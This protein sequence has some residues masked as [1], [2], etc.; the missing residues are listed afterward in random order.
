MNDILKAHSSAWLNA[1][2]YRLAWL[3][4]PI[5]LATLIFGLQF[6]ITPGNNLRVIQVPLSYSESENK[7]IS[8]GLQRKDSAT[9]QALRSAAEDDDLRALNYMGLLHE[10]NGPYPGTVA[11][12]SDVALAYYDKAAALGSVH[13]LMN[14]G[15]LLARVSYS[16]KACSYFER[17]FKADPTRD[18][19]R[20]EAGY[21][22]AT[23]PNVSASEKA[24]GIEMMESA[25][26]SGFVR[27]FGLLGNTY[28]HQ[29]P[30][31]FNQ[32]KGNFEKAI[33]GNIDDSGFSYGELGHLYFFGNGI[34]QD[35]KKAVALYLEGA[36][37]GSSGSAL[38]LSFIYT[39]GNHGEP[40]DY[41]K[42]LE[43]A[44]LSARGGNAKGHF[45]V[46]LAY[47]NGRGTPRDYGLAAQHC[48]NAISLGDESIFEYVKLDNKAVPFEFIRALQSRLSK[49]VLYTGS[50]DGRINPALLESMRS[51]LNKRQLFE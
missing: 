2:A 35:Y 23:T 19:A 34:A 4:G 42:A 29:S 7:A 21:C 22:L 16:D 40:A 46:Y 6:W 30:P 10:P 9:L 11:E 47:L 45:H 5:A 14:A 17:A 36:K 13:A 33:A 26:A 49:A 32:A 27:A 8:E 41:K 50:I 1:K 28:L 38:N 24:R 43:Y 39:S 25:A 44:L 3:L 37:R 18:D 31:D 48:L 51:L 15:S 12:N 20:G